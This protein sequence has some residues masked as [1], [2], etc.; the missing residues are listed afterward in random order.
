VKPPVSS[1]R[2]GPPKDATPEI[3]NDLES[4]ETALIASLIT[5]A[6]RLPA[7]TLGA[8][9][10]GSFALVLASMGPLSLLSRPLSLLGF[11]VGV[12]GIAFPGLC[13]GVA[14]GF[15]IAATALCLGVFLFAG[16]GAGSAARRPPTL[17]AIPLG[18]G[19]MVANAPIGDGD[20]VN[21][22][23][24]AVRRQNLRVEV[25]AVTV[26]PVRLKD[27]D[28]EIVTTE[29]HLVIHLRVGYE[30]IT[31][32]GIPYKPWADRP[33]AA[34]G[35]APVLTDNRGHRYAQDTFDAG[36]KVVGRRD[37]EEILTIGHQVREVL[38]F[39]ALPPAV[40]YLRL[41]LPVSAFGAAGV[42]RFQIPRSLIQFSG[43]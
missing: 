39:P 19:G 35:H 26:A 22:S 25:T 41:E 10:L 8:F 32:Q 18:G 28:M 31:F 30:G 20:W 37:T 24:H 6:S 38:V 40:D 11:L 16:K 34:S 14:R 12:A 3:N 36:L 4:A 29:P 27:P 5:R 33:G 23:T 21:A 9:F 7:C 42:V 43:S 1:E 13:K 2:P 17:V 15:P